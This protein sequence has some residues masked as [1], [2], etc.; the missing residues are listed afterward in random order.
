MPATPCVNTYE[1]SFQMTDEEAYY[2]YIH[3]KTRI[4]VECAF[5]M[6][7]SRFR[8]LKRELDCKD[9][10]H[11]CLI[12]AG[13]MVLH[14]MLLAVNDDYVAETYDQ[15]PQLQSRNVPQVASSNNLQEGMSKRDQMKTYLYSIKQ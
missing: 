2:N 7:K 12:V 8:I 3:S 14:N 9:M 1:I 4:A 11:A 15:D 5:G 6:L 10:E 13:C